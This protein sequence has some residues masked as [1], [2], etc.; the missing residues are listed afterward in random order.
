MA[1]QRG[2]GCTLCLNPFLQ[3]LPVVVIYDNFGLKGLQVHT[4]A[5]KNASLPPSRTPKPATAATTELLYHFA[6]L[7][8]TH[9]SKVVQV[10]AGGFVLC[11]L[12]ALRVRDAQRATL[13]FPESGDAAI[14][15]TC[16]TSKHPSRR[17]AK[18]MPIFVPPTSETLGD[19]SKA[20]DARVAAGLQPDY[21]LPRIKVPRGKKIHDAGVEFLD[22][23]AKSADVIKAMRWLL[24]MGSFM[25]SAEAQA[26]S[27]HSARHWAVTVARLLAMPIA[28]MN[29]VGRWIAAVIDAQ[30]RRAS[31]PNRYSAADGEAPRVLAVLTKIVAMT[32]E[33]V[34]RAGG[35]PKLPRH[36]PSTEQHCIVYET[37]GTQYGG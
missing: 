26:F 1:E 9:A 16:F 28:D 10:Y 20:L 6:S 29:E 8:T 18:E 15:G 5:F 31:M 22:G 27:G 19:W 11:M 2:R 33:R 24:M 37:C 4:P 14:L 3:L 36:A 30:T 12:A 17:Q 7:S 32:H 34:K 21:T 35:A 13:T 23:P 25:T